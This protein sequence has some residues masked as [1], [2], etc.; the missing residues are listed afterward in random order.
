RMTSPPSSASDVILDTTVTWKDIEERIRHEL[1]TKA[2]LGP[3][4]AVQLIG[5][6]NGFMSRVV[7]MDT[8]LQGDV[9]SIPPRIVVKIISRVAGAELGDSFK[10]HTE[11]EKL[12]EGYD[13][14]I[15]Q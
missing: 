7:I 12:F 11:D 10:D 2:I 8:D 15:R 4:R 5:E 14:L 13:E 6:G 9:S 3:K 1:G